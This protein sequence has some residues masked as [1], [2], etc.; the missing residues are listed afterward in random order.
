MIPRP[1]VTESK[2]CIRKLKKR[3]EK[4]WDEWVWQDHNQD[5]VLSGA[6]EEPVKAIEPNQDGHRSRPKEE[7]APLGAQPKP[8]LFDSGNTQLLVGG[9]Q[10][11]LPKQPP[12][13]SYSVFPDAASTPQRTFNA[14]QSGSIMNSGTYDVKPLISLERA[15]LPVFSGDMQDYYRWKAEWEDLQQLGNPHGLENVR[16]FHLLGSLDGKVKRDLVLSSCGSADDVFRV[17]DNKYGNNTSPHKGKPTQKDYRINSGR[18]ES[19]S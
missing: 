13:L 11:H 6:E 3:R 15:W 7:A 18:G 4:L 1:N 17:L 8:D 14:Q 5:W 2:E 9:I 10:P 19:T 16:K 12:H